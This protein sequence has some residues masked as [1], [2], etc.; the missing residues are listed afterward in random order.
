MSDIINDTLT[1]E[2]HINAPIAEVWDAYVDPEKRAQWSV[3]DGE[4]MVYDEVD[5]REQGRELYRC[6][7]PETLD[8]HAT[9]EYSRIVPQTLIVYTETVR[10]AGQPLSTGIVTWEFEPTQEGTHVKITNQFVSFVGEGMIDG[11]RNGHNKALAQLNEFLATPTSRE[12]A[13]ITETTRR[14]VTP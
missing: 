5:F 10:S 1:L 11:N 12:L 3:P 2:R 7:P 13:N 4:A 6:G 8:F 14:Q 9:V